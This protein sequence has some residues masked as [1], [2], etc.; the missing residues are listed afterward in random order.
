MLLGSL[1]RVV[2]VGGGDSVFQ[3]TGMIEWGQK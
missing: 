3:V 2:V 1:P